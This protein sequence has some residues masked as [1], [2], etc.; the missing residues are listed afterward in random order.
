MTKPTPLTTAQRVACLCLWALTTAPWL[1]AAGPGIDPKAAAAA[2]QILTVTGIRGGLVVH[3]G[4]GNGRLTAALWEAASHEPRA[5]SDAAPKLG[6]RS[7]ALVPSFLVHG[8]DRD[9]KAVAEARRTIRS[10]GLYGPVAADRLTSPRL[11]YID[12]LVNLVVAEDLGDVPMAEVLRV[13]CPDGVACVRR[14]DAWAKTVKPRPKDIDE[15]THFLHDASNNPVAHD[16]VVGPPRRL[17]WVGSPRYARHHDRMSSVSAVVSAGGRVFTIFDEASR[18]SVLVPPTWRLI[19]RDAFNGTILWKR[20]IETWHTHLFGLKSGP[21]VLP[22]RLVAAGGRVYVTLGLDAPLT[23]LDA[24]TGRTVHTYES[25]A[26]TR[27]VLLSDGVLFLVAGGGEPAPADAAPRPKGRRR[28]QG[29]WSEGERRILAVNAQS[30]EVLWAASHWVAQLTLAATSDGVYFCSRD[31]IVCLDR[32]T[33]KLAWQSDP[34]PRGAQFPSYYAPTLVVHGGV[35]LFAGGETA[36]AKARTWYTEGKDTMT[37]L[38]AKTG[39]ALWSAYHPPS[40][41]ASP[42]D[43]FV[44]GGLVWTGETTSGRAVGVFTGRDLRTGEVKSEFP[45]D[46]ETYW[47]HHRCHRGKATDNF[48]LTSR[49]GVEFIDVRRRRW[50]TNHW[51]RGACLYGIMPANGLLYAPQHPCACYLESKLSGFNALAPA[52][53]KP[54]ADE[55]AAPTLERGPAYAKAQHPASSI[56]HPEDWPTYRH[57]AAR[58]G[59]TKVAV[60]ASLKQAWAAE[61]GGKL[62]SPVV[63]GGRVFVASVDEHTVHALDAGGGKKLWQFTAG[64]RVDS[65]PTVW[66]GLVLFGSADGHVYCLREAAGALVWRFRAAPRDRRLMSFEQL[67]SVWPVHGSIL[68]HEGV[69][70][71]VAGRSV[72]LDGGL[73]F[74]RLDPATGR[75]LSETVLSEREQDTGKDH[76]A[77]VSWL[78]MPT[79]LPDVLSTDGR[80]LFM[81]SQPFRLDGT[82]LPL[83]AMSRGGNADAGA[84]P[85]T[86]NPELAHLF[87]PTG[88]LDD[89]WWHRTYW[90]YGSCFVS[91]WQGYYRAG[92]ATP[93]GRILVF[94]DSRV[95]G[96]GRKPQY[97][98]WTTPIE[99]HLFAA[100]KV[101]PAPDRRAAPATR[102]TRVRVAKS[103]SLNP[104]GKPLTVAAWVKAEGPNGVVLARGGGAQGYT[105]YLSGGRPHFAVRSGGKLGAVAAKEKVTGRWAHVAGVLAEDA[106]LRIYVDGKLRGSAKAPALVAA[107]PLEA[108]EIGGDDES[109]VGDYDGP[110]AFAGLIDGVRIYHQ[111]LSAEAVAQH[112]AGEPVAEPRPVLALSFDDGK[113]QDGSGNANHGTVDGAAAAQGKVGGALKFTG[114]GGAARVRGMAYGFH[115]SQDVPL[116]ARA[117]VLAADTLFIAGPPDPVDET[118]LFRRLSDP[119]AQQQ[120]ADY[121]AALA[122]QKGGLLRAVSARDGATLAESTLDTPPVFDGMAAAAGRLFIA[123]TGGR[124]L[125]LAGAGP[126]K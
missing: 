118:R 42:E 23:A 46:V 106:T 7:L 69:A 125:C 5:A 75:V 98:R 47:F 91:G 19:A 22:R 63:A 101:Q 117:M 72:F 32:A 120:L 1:G 87:S 20:P 44:V 64:G 10:L 57:D 78:N 99:H 88:F 84:P 104:A 77:F 34:V 124:V 25:T 59:R 16:D 76:Q 39:K 58:S 18:L 96:F 40:G 94:D 35:V 105:L 11:P 85:A 12:N 54:A 81:R 9:P 65:P 6:A 103:K 80:H 119:D 89:S 17:Q 108:M 116:F 60:P 79:A 43:V 50:L 15:W 48:L 71:F 95:F 73:R 27:E 114:G 33:G 97:F 36:S 13:L 107:D 109:C 2:R 70:C 111:A 56:Q 83:E 122:G 90:L 45:P 74:F 3:V 31:R 86:Q 123:T 55:P 24:A 8:L 102:V 67:E 38:S 66:R 92:K 4:C 49:A 30:G 21:A 62:S 93:S 126:A 110:M 121:A 115:W 100:S 28:S 53:A 14:G 112:A 113:A 68:V 61:I 52:P 29:W 41:Y 51:V 37:A 82:R 26:A